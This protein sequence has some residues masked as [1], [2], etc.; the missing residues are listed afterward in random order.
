[1]DKLLQKIF[2]RVIYYEE[3]VQDAEKRLEDKMHDLLRPYLNQ[4]SDEDMESIKNLVYAVEVKA[5]QEGYRI[6]IRHAVLGL[7]ALLKKS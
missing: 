7:L 2:E 4:Y 5:M 1:M 6:G 3:D